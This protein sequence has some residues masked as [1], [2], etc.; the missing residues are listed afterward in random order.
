[1]Q[2][3]QCS[4]VDDAMVVVNSCKDNQRG[5]AISA[6]ILKFVWL[7]E[8]LVWA[9]LQGSVPCVGLISLVQ[10]PE[11]QKGSTRATRKFHLPSQFD[12]SRRT[13]SSYVPW[14]GT[15]SLLIH[16]EGEKNRRRQR[17]DTLE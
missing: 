9:R 2:F 3:K 14:K 12:P 7:I 13:I 8:I 1:M 11:P 6:V 10:T 5:I 17:K 4:S 15:P 16:E